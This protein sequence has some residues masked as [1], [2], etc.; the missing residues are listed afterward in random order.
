M[1][2]DRRVLILFEGKTDRKLFSTLRNFGT[3]SSLL[4]EDAY[5][6][7]LLRTSIYELYE[8]LIESGEYDSLLVYL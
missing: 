3:F 4:D 1:T 7:V 8:P 5:V 6:P 2:S